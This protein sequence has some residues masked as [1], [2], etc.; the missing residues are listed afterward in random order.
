[1]LRCFKL[2]LDAG[3][4]KL[5]TQGPEK[6]YQDQADALAAFQAFTQATGLTPSITVSSG[7]GLHVYYVLDA[8][9]KPDQWQPVSKAFHKFCKGHGLKV[10]AAVTSDHSRVL[11]PVGTLHPNGRRVE[12]LECTGK[13][14]SLYEFAGIVRADGDTDDD[15]LTLGYA[16][17]DLSVNEELGLVVQGPPKSIRKVLLRCEAM[18]NAYEDQAHVEEPYW[19]AVIGV[20]KHTVEGLEA[21]HLMSSKHPSYDAEEVEDKFNRWETGPATCDTF[22]EFA[23]AQCSACP[24]RGKIKSP[25]VLGSEPDLS[26]PGVFAATEAANVPGWVAQINMRHAVVRMG[27]DLVIADNQ[28]PT[29]SGRGIV[30]GL[31]WLGITAF[32]QMYKGRT[33]EVETGTGC[34]TKRI[35]LADAWLANTGRQQFEGAVFAPGEAVPATILNL[36]QGFAVAGVAGDVSPWLSLLEA[37]V[38]DPA[39][40]EYVLKWL[41]WKVQN[42]GGVPDTILIL[43]GSKGT[44]KNS[45]FDPVLILFGRHGMLADDPE[46]IAGR[47]TWH[48]MDKCF[49]VLDEAVFIGDPRQQDRIK[50]RTTAKIMLYEQK[51]MDPVQGVNRCAYVML[52]NH[53]HVWQSTKDERRAVPIEVGDALRGNLTFWN[54]YHALVKG[55]GPAALLHHLQHVDISGFNPRRIP[56]GETLRK[57]IE[58]TALRDPAVA[59]WHQCLSEGGIRW[60]DGGIERVTPLSAVEVTLVDAHA[61][62]ESYEQAAGSRSRNVMG[63][64][65]V[66]KRLHGWCGPEGL[67]KSRPRS[68]EGEQR[69]PRYTV[70]PLSV[71][72]WYFKDATGVEITP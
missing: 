39:E 22:S 19:R 66:A 28:T 35:A 5:A 2:D 24:H 33:V 72:R 62:R 60:R 69:Q 17:Y 7:E 51:G 38:T 59:W 14:Y 65:Q 46:L 30:Y 34:E 58:M 68:G 71:L 3:E 70:P 12:V 4:K 18:R 53:E 40:R 16:G 20:C 23:S 29:M 41:A 37:L 52:T 31:G 25:I 47:F 1:M 67:N 27:S 45:L 6:V 56:K 55:E 43:T 49:A 36:Y 10:D 11:R 57:Q 32:R 8:D 26:P 44:G 9:V 50:S 61:V 13:V 42:P 48:L 63:W 15:V 54:N 64:A 21:A